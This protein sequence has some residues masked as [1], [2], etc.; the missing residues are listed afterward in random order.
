MRTIT[1]ETNQIAINLS[2]ENIH[3]LD[4]TD[5]ESREMHH[6]TISIEIFQGR[7]KKLLMKKQGL[8]EADIKKRRQIQNLDLY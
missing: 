3:I 1:W 8:E 4:K 6:Q 7:N 2:N 5:P